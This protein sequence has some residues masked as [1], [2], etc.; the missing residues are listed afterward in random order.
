MRILLLALLVVVWGPMAGAANVAT[1]DLVTTATV[2]AQKPWNLLLDMN[3]QP[4]LRDDQ[5]KYTDYTMF[6]NY[7]INSTHS[8]RITQGMTQKYEIG[9]DQGENEFELSDTVLSHFW[10]LPYV[11]GPF[12]FRWVSGVFLPASIDSQDNSKITTLSGSLHA[13]AFFA[14]MYSLSV[15][16]FARYN[17]YEYKTSLGGTPLPAFTTGITIVNT[18]DITDKLSLNG[19]FS[20]NYIYD[21]ASQYET[22]TRYG[23]F[24]DNARGRYGI[25]VAVNYSVTNEFG[26]YGGYSEGDAYIRD[27]RY[28][29]YAY[30]PETSRLSAGLTLYF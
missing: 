13:N 22:S 10:N 7:K 11:A 8:V 6:V 2:Q 21:Y 20:Y 16:P 3:Y 4:A 30:D 5:F 1:T 24:D 14:G 9:L 18:I 28:E 12:R 25:D 19:T 29:V 15:R 17:W 26:V 27:G 23:Y